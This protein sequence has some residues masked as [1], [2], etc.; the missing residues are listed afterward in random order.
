MTI[1]LPRLPADPLAP[2]PPAADALA[3]PDGLLAWG[4]DLSPARLLN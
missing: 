3:E 1:R 4:G 2:F